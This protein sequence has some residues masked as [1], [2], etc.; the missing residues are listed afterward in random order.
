MANAQDE[1]QAPASPSSASALLHPLLA[2]VVALILTTFIFQSIPG[3]TVM[4]SLVQGAILSALMLVI[5]HFSD[6]RALASPASSGVLGRWI[7]Y[8]LLVAAVSGVVTFYLARTGLRGLD[9]SDIAMRA[10]IVCGVC[11]MTGIYEEALFRVLAINAFVRAFVSKDRKSDAASQETAAFYAS[12]VTYASHPAAS[13]VSSASASPAVSPAKTSPAFK[14]ALISALLFAFLHIS[15]AGI[16][17][18]YAMV[19]LQTVIKF[20]QTALFGFIMAAFYVRTRS[21]WLI[22]L[23]HAVFDI[24]YL[25]PIMLTLGIPSSLVTNE[26]LNLILLAITSALLVAPAVTAAQ[27][28]NES[29]SYEFESEAVDA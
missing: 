13:R 10:C 4:W 26:P 22:A 8:V 25:G 21:V 17:S 12:R 2:F 16:T 15:V 6:R 11:F 14:A 29:D 23:L 19:Q 9:V 1:F 24:L 5:V 7:I 3:T 20:I 27:V 28:L 18:E